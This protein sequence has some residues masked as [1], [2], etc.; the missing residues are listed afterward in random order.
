MFSNTGAYNPIIGGNQIVPQMNQLPGL[1]VL[2]HGIE[3]L[4]FT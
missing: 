2:C 3:K 1:H 4:M